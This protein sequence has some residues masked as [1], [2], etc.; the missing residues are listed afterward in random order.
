MKGKAMLGALRHALPRQH[1]TVVAYVALF[2]ALGGTATAA[3]L[4]TGKNVK[5]GS[6]TGADVKSNSLGSVDVTNGDLLAEDFKA[7]QLRAGPR[8]APGAPGARGA[9]GPAGAK[10]DQGSPG[11]SGLV[12]V[13]QGSASNSDS[14]KDATATCPAGKRVIGTG[15]YI[16]GG[17]SGSSPSSLTDVVLDGILPTRETQ[18]PGFVYVAATEEEPTDL[19]WKVVAVALCASVS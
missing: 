14:F 15:G 1:A 5:N 17:K 13:E 19:S 12:K 8:G 3:V 11:I 6:L 10:G 16:T 7:G 2:V 4:V 9:P 18:V